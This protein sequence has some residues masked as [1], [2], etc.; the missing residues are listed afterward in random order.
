MSDTLSEFEQ[1][2]LL[3]LFRS[4]EEAYVASLHEEILRR[5]GR[6]AAV[7][8]IYVTLG[9]L[10]KKGFVTERHEL[11]ATSRGGQARKLFVLSDEGRAA[12]VRTRNFLD[13]LWAGFELPTPD[14]SR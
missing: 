7:P 12:L 13:R 6:N 2:V 4:G 1:V 8:T 3:A 14:G 5:T 11:S 10:K 9:R